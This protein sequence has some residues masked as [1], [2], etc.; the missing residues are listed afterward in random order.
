MKNSL[1]HDVTPDIV[2]LENISIAFGNHIIHS[3]LSFSIA[4]GSVVTILGPSGTGKTVLL[5]LIVGLLKPGTGVLK[6]LGQ[7][8]T[9]LTEQ[10]LFPI[11]EKVGMLFQGAALFDSLS[12]FENIA[13]GIRERGETDEELIASIV[14]EKLEFVGLGHT[15]NKFPAELSG[16]QKK[17]VGL[18]RAL[19][20]SPEILL[21]DE[22]T[23][24]LDPTSIRRIDDLIVRLREE[25]GVT[26]IIV[27]HD[28]ASAERIS[29]RWILLGNGHVL[30]DGSPRQLMEENET[31]L[32]FIDGR[33]DDF[34]PQGYTR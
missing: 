1:S 15:V 23:T 11:R 10:Q 8:I 14:S 5:K 6:V 12:V 17:R 22:P 30:A 26:S 3:S 27:T 19:A 21:F 9:R 33:W 34:S 7:D 18:A 16:G 4:R 13:Y 24:G 32:S 2:E 28:I 20:S 31:L 25:Q 29:D